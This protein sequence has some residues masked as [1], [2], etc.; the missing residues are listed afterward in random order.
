MSHFGGSSKGSLSGKMSENSAKSGVMQGSL[1]LTLRLPEGESSAKNISVLSSDARV[2]SSARDMMLTMSGDM[3]VVQGFLGMFGDAWDGV[4]T[5][6][7]K[8]ISWVC[9]LIKGFHFSSQGLPRIMSLLG[10]EVTW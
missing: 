8:Q 1:S 2:S 9:Q 4:G 7:G 3:M 5:G 10:S 6:L